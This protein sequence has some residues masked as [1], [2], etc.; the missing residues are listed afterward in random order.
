[1]DTLKVEDGCKG[2]DHAD[3]C[4][5]MYCTILSKPNG[6][7]T[8]NKDTN[9]PNTKPKPKPNT[10]MIHEWHCRSATETRL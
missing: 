3:G 6:R 2:I 7:L 4:S 1:M 10:F 8:M 9:H 5:H